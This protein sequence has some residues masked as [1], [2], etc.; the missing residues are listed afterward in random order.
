MLGTLSFLQRPHG[1]TR[2]LKDLITIL[3]A[4]T[5]HRGRDRE[6]RQDCSSNFPGHIV[7]QK[8]H[9]EINEKQNDQILKW[10]HL[11]SRKQNWC[12]YCWLVPLRSENVRRKCWEVAQAECS[13]QLYNGCSHQLRRCSQLPPWSGGRGTLLLS[14]GDHTRC[15][16]ECTLCLTKEKKMEKKNLETGNLNNLGTFPDFKIH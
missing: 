5:A 3:R 1:E 12:Y 10:S 7:P 16:G 13:T 8:T 14:W 4:G 15:P 11:D 9:M 2:G 6:K